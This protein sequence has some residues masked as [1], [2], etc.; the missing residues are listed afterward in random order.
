[1]LVVTIWLQNSELVLLCLHLSHGLCVVSQCVPVISTYEGGQRVGSS[2][3]GPKSE[4]S[5]ASLESFSC[6]FFTAAA[7]IQAGES[8]HP[9]PISRIN[10]MKI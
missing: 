10:L 1:M 6:F 7:E 3:T 9:S 2:F 5:A 8:P 4:I